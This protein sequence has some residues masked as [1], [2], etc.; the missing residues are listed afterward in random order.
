MTKNS[1]AKLIKDFV[2]YYIAVKPA[3][4]IFTIPLHAS[5]PKHLHL[6]RDD[7]QVQ[8]RQYQ[9]HS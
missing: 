5:R 6:I 3:I 7:A 2:P 8:I 9:R 1:K 4:K